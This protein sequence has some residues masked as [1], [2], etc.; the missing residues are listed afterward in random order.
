MKEIL[1]DPFYK[2]CARDKDGNCDGRI[3]FE[4]ALIFGNKQVQ[5]KY[6][7][8]P[9]CEYHHAV[10]IHQDGGELNKEINVW[11]ALN[12]ASNDELRG[13]SK[14]IDYLKRREYLN[15]KYGIYKK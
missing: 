9:L 11:I 4:H 10:G 3:T 1:A 15:G 14:A 5:M 7:I 8:I 2:R 6:A 13:I 12:R